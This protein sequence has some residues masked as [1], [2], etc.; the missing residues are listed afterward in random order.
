MN[1]G[2][3]FKSGL[4]RFDGLSSPTIGP[5]SEEPVHLPGTVTVGYTSTTP[6]YQIFL[7][8]PQTEVGSYVSD[9]II[10]RNL[11]RPAMQDS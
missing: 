2:R 9:A 4:P 10:K 3:H 11:S 7:A 5:V 8:I 6:T 1:S